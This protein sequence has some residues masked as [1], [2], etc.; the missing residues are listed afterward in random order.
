MLVRFHLAW[1]ALG[2]AT[3]SSLAITL[4]DTG[5][6]DKMGSI[7]PAPHAEAYAALVVQ[8]VR[9]GI[10]YRT[11]GLGWEHPT[12]RTA[13]REASGASFSASASRQRQERSLERL[14][15]LGYSI[16]SG[17]SLGRVE[18]ELIQALCDEISRPE[19]AAKATFDAVS[20]A[21]GA[22]LLLPL[23]A[24]SEGI[25]SM[26][27]TLNGAPVPREAVEAT[28][29]SII[30]HVLDGTFA[31]WRYVN[32]TGR[33]QLDGLSQAQI[34]VWR[35]STTIRHAPSLETHEDRKGEL[36]FFWATKIGGPSH[37]FDVEG[38]CLLPLLANARHKV[39]LVSDAAWPHH[40]AGRAHFRLL[41]MA[42][43][44]KPLLWLET[45]NVDFAAEGQVD[46][47]KWQRAVL[48]H[49]ISKA[50]RMGIALSV[51]SR[52]AQAIS[53]HPDALRGGVR[54]VNDQLLLRPS[55]GVVEASD[56]LTI[57]HDWVQQEDE[58]TPPLRRAL[59]EPASSSKLEL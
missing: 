5:L 24:L 10:D 36:G 56:Y 42:H 49:A 22:E 34:D 45:V 3:A 23:R 30:S 12:T 16:T 26:T 47:S 59:Y 2:Q 7:L 44:V 53:S 25:P 33:R 54:I 27:R 1:M 57:K 46:S 41:W 15:E 13:Y 43:H 39:I 29:Q 6:A 8:A 50:N 20:A 32:P 58:V 55:N 18:A 52:L 35:E 17:M 4:N 21:L 40:P 31:E 11:L 38:Q 14:R 51:E 19:M 37:G 48:S 9:S 28:V